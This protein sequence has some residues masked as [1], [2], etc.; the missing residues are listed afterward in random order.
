MISL[1]ISNSIFCFSL[2]ET[3][4]DNIIFNEYITRNL[5]DSFDPLE[6]E[7]FKGE[8]LRSGFIN[9]DGK[10]RIVSEVLA[11]RWIKFKKG[12]FLH[13]AGLRNHIAHGVMNFDPSGQLGVEICLYGCKMEKID[14][15]E[16]E[17]NEEKMAEAELELDGVYYELGM[18]VAD[19]VG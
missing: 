17:K 14:F 7:N 2:L 12:I 13:I 10:V 16:L 4:L 8:I 19:K 15:Q 11:R 5:L 3:R 18:F 6:L 9:F 1:I